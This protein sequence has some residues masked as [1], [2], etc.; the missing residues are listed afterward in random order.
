[1]VSTA[2]LGAWSPSLFQSD[3]ISCPKLVA[4]AGDLVATWREVWGPFWARP[5][6]FPSENRSGF[7]SALR[8]P[9][10]RSVLVI[11]RN[12]HHVHAAQG[13]GALDLRKILVCASVAGNQ[14]VV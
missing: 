7:S 14:L 2:G 1:M 13:F 6:G 10:N 5:F 4:Q 9:W 11:G 3:W 12:L 8:A